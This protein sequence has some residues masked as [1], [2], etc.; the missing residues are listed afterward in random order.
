VVSG[1]GPWISYIISHEVL[2]MGS[3]WLQ[4][5]NVHQAVSAFNMVLSTADPQATRC[6]VGRRPRYLYA[7][8]LQDACAYR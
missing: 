7:G 8:L 6:I 5:G 3:G 2:Q 1:I 4:E